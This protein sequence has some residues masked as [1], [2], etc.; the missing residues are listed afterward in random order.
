MR[1]RGT[2]SAVL[3]AIALAATGVTAGDAASPLDGPWPQAAGEMVV[4]T[5]AKSSCTVTVVT[6]Y[7]FKN[8]AYGPDHYFSG[9]YTPPADCPGPWA[10]VVLT[11]S[12][13][14]TP[15]TQF[16]RIGDVVIGGIEL[17]HLTTPE[18]AFGTTTWKVQRDVT[19][20]TA[21][22]MAP[23]PVV[24]GIGN[25]VTS[26]YTGIFYGTLQLT[27]YR[28]GGTT[29][30]A[31]HPDVV[32]QGPSSLPSISSQW[33]GKPSDRPTTAVTFPA[34]LT[35][36]TAEVFASGHGGCEEDWWYQPFV[37][38]GVPYR[39][40][41]VYVDG[42]LGGVAPIY[43]TLFTG[44]WGPDWWRP[45]PSP[46]TFNLRPYLLDLTPFVGLLTDG[47]PHNISVGMLD[48]LQYK[49]GD[50][51]PTA[52]NLLGTTNHASSAR[53]VGGLTSAPGAATPSNSTVG[54]TGAAL[55]KF[56]ASHALDITG[57]SQPAGGSV[58]T[59][60]VHEYLTDAAEMA[61]AVTKNN[62]HWENTTT[63]AVAG[64]TQVSSAFATYRLI[65]DGARFAFTDAAGTS[66]RRDG[67]T[68]FTSHLDDRMQTSGPALVT[69]LVG[70]SEERWAYSDSKGRCLT[71]TLV[72][73]L[74]KV[75]LDNV[76]TG[77]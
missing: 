75:I 67:A 69:G 20:A 24:F 68:L 6:D 47:V 48:W 58:T 5:P 11:M 65:R 1:M 71:H 36:L 39:E 23:Q 37:C 12:A 76:A 17:L 64:H 45:I 16:D 35:G 25:V 34:N 59:T 2:I 51:W 9:T 52:V 18:G 21:T 70:A 33:L 14:V 66:M 40:I 44:G 57:W 72:G 42:R 63:T 73:L 22:L 8:S 38:P 3:T 4:L 31:D 49:A 19:D 10:Q 53:T 46:R 74:G 43:P 50:Y 61:A 60:W 29:P 56:N 26:T 55:I 28:A 41:A 15:G 30:V 7:P 32:L 62:W 77:C 27:F 54:S 13:S